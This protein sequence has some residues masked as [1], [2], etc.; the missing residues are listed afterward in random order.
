MSLNKFKQ[1]NN[2]CTDACCSGIHN[3]HEADTAEP[4]QSG[5]TVFS[6]SGLDC[7]DCAAKLEKRIAM[8]KGV[9]AAK[10]N[11]STSK[12]TVTHSVSERDI[13]TTVQQAGYQ[14][15]RHGGKIIS[16]P[17]WKQSRMLAAAASGIL[18]AAAL[19]IDR[20]GLNAIPLYIMV[21]LTGGFHVAKSGFYALKSMTLDMNFLMVTAALGA[22]AIGEW[23]EGATVVFLFAFGNAL[24]AY[25]MDKTRSSIRSLMELAPPEALVRI[26]GNEIR[27]RVEEISI[28]DTVIVKPGER[29]A[30][31]GTVSGG[32]SAVNQAAITGESMPVNKQIGDSVYAGT[33]NTHGA[34][35]ITVTRKAGDS[36]LAKIMHSVEEAQAQKAPMQQF[37]DVFAKYY[38][39]A[40]IL[41]AVLIAAVPPLFFGAEFGTWFYRALVLL[42]ISCPCA[43]V[44]ST[45]V[46]IVSA[47]GNSSRN[48]VLIKGGVFMERLGQVKA[49]AFDKTGTLTHGRP[50]ITDVLSFEPSFTAEKL[51][52]LAAAVERWSEHPVAK[53]VT[54]GATDF[55]ALPSE[56]FM[57]FP[58][59]G[60][61][62]DVNGQTVYVGNARFF[63][64]SGFNTG[65]YDTD[66]SKLE[67]QGKTVIFIGYAKTVCGAVAVADTL[68]HNSREA[69]QALR[70]AGI[71]HITMLTGDNSR[72]AAA[73]SSVLDT[74]G[75][76]SGLLPEDKAA[77]VRELKSKYGTVAMIGD[78][79][80][81]APALALADIGIAMGVAGSDTALETADIA[82]MSDELNKLPYVIKLSRKTLAVIKQNITFSIGLKVLFIAG[83][84][85]GFVNLWLA[86]LADMG[87]SLIVTLNG[88]RLIRK[89]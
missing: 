70:K 40:V 7:A 16:N 48:G 38:T 54:A 53:A 13:I 59:R 37:V 57:A 9:S 88:M 85:F 45:P 61:K 82:L 20:A 77:A 81:D 43:L 1:L 49:V 79:V 87:A 44:I 46:S 26:N 28:G 27:T 31:D 42:V 80:N 21:M 78:G 68:R 24:Q 33:V 14:A 72:A 76:Y 36:T 3:E 64:E 41:F 63:E 50:E 30:V 47:I 66:V 8:M 25:T 52:S 2:K 6:L 10:V 56:N 23:S 35:E 12:M 58:G 5:A 83:T 32:S 17:W 60:A 89:I 86:V 69:V 74:D 11:F 39:P 19:M 84:F 73:I 15:V 29:I 4:V 71:S 62:A 65:R 67:E 22:A 34:L 18:L 75:V 51:L 55:P